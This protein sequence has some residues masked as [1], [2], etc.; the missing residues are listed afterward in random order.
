MAHLNKERKKSVPVCN[1][2]G[3]EL[4][5]EKGIMLEDAFQVT[6]EWGFFSSRDLEVHR[7]T[8]CESCY[9]HMI[10]EFK[11]P[12]EVYDKKEAL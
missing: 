12:I 5:V 7:F 10:S 4:R 6:K 1:V 3:R 11:I 8:M 2:C 9:D